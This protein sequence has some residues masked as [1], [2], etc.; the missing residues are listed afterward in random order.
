MV[1]NG[2]LAVFDGF[3]MLGKAFIGKVL[4]RAREVAPG[5]ESSLAGLDCIMPG[6]AA[7]ACGR[8][9]AFANLWYAKPSCQGV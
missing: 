3:S 6:H 2:G 8:P 1:Q 4:Y 5:A 7:Q 9:S